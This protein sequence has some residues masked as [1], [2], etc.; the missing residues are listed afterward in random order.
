MNKK[1][2]L[3]VL[4]LTLL[5]GCSS[6][7]ESK[8][9]DYK[10]LSIEHQFAIVNA[11]HDVDVKDR[12][13]I[14]AK[15]LLIRSSEQY[16]DTQENI[17]DMAVKASKMMKDEGINSTPLEV[18]E[19]T[20]LAYI[21]DSNFAENAGLYAGLRKDGQPHAEAMIAVKGILKCLNVTC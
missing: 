1:N 16:G 3:V 2:L 15:E 9:L 19:A 8:N 6:G 12:T 20:T 18:L 7:D 21:K 13:T 5:S 11:G 4:M 10:N 14:R 17:A